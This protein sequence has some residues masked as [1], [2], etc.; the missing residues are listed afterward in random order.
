MTRFRPHL[1]AA[2]VAAA[3]AALVAGPA[4]AA[5]GGV[6]LTPVGRVPF[7]DRAY[8]LDLPR[9]VRVG[10]VDA[11]VHENGRLVRDATLTPVGASDIRFGA[12]LAVDSSLSMKGAPFFAAL[13]AARTFVAHRPGNERVA[14]VAFNGHIHVVQPPTTSAQ[15]LDRAFAHPPTLAYG[16]R[17]FDALNRSIVLLERDRI[18][19][20]S[21]VLL[22]DGTDVGSTSTLASV[23]AR[24]RRDHI[25]VFTVGLRSKSFDAVPLR[26]LAE[27]T[28]GSFTE[29]ASLAQLDQ[30]YA[31]ISGRLANEYLLEY[32][33]TVSPGTAVHVTAQIADVGTGG[34][35]YT[36]PKPSELQPFHRSLLTRF[37]V[38]PLSLVVL[39]IL[40]AALAGGAIFRLL[41]L[42]TAHGLVG[43]IGAFVVT[44]RAAAAVADRRRRARRAGAEA[45]G[46]IG[47]LTAK[48]ENDFEL[49][50][51]S[52]PPNL[53][54]LGTTAVTLGTGLLLGALAL[55][56]VLLAALVPLF[57]FGWV[58]RRV[59]RVRDRF[60]DQLPET[61]QLLA[62][63]LRSGHSLIGAL[64]VVV[65]NAPEPSRREFQQVVND[66]RIG[67]PIEDSLRRI[68][69]RMKNRDMTQVALLSELQR[70]AGGNA[71]DVLD[72]VVATVR[73]RGEIR[74]LARTLTVQGRMARWILTV[75]P[76]V[77]ALV[78]LVLMPTITK[79]LF[80]STG[81]QLALV[82]AALLVAVG[83]FWIQN[84]IEIEV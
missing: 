75:L 9:Q 48:L 14:L 54:L 2:L 35:Q 53:F 30:V 71:A 27:Q 42:G 45:R 32:R 47:R 83:S 43:R 63:A 68:G 28:G 31:Q 78:M 56:L 13:D 29:T 40:A 79:P 16:T 49:G 41:Q 55:P 22:S 74:R 73:E 57:A 80:E 11:V 21:I 23:A 34:S 72:A 5:G 46:L 77:L 64:S 4:S 37:L 59:K 70:T 66:D 10:R 26:Q 19:A 24:A 76:A 20:G 82:F 65:E 33:S 58:G 18:S 8:V 17:I 84:I 3:L 44:P 52:F 81:G 1:V 51:I 7:P 62:S 25:R 67:I 15:A 69:A 60:A 39:S 61:L 36:A 50:E 12:V 6:R 38:S